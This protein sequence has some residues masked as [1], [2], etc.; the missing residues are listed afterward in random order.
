MRVCF[1]GD[2]V[3]SAG[4]RAFKTVMPSFL[5]NNAI[6][7]CIVNAENSVNGL[8]ASINMLRD[9][10]AAGADLFTMGNHTFSNRDF[11]SQINPRSI[12]WQGLQTS[13]LRGPEMITVFSRRTGRSWVCLISWVRFTLMCC[14]IILSPALTGSLTGLS[15]LKYAVP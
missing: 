2:V 9:L 7:C 15:V 5:R 10:E 13:V 8:G 11:L 3:G 4:R 6:D 12:M 1:V 14:L